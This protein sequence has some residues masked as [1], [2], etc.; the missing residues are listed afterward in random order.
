VPEQNVRFIASRLPYQPHQF[1]CCAFVNNSLLKS[2]LWD[3]IYGF[4]P[5]IVII[6]Q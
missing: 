1:S 2:E 4:L 3:R 6:I 5:A